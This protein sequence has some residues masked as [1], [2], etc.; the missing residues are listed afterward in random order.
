M[1][2]SNSQQALRLCISIV[3]YQSRR[4]ELEALFSSLESSIIYV[5]Q[6]MGVAVQVVL[7]DNGQQLSLL[8]KVLEGYPALEPEYL[9]VETNIG[10]GCA[11]NL[12]ISSTTADYHLVMNPDLVLKPDTLLK[13]L[14]ELERNKTIVALIPEVC[15]DTGRRQYLCKNYPTVFALALRGFAPAWLR[16]IFDQTLANYECRAMVDRGLNCQVKLASGCFMLCRGAALRQLKGFDPRF[17]LYFEDFALSLELARLG[18]LNYYPSMQIAHFGGHAARKG[19][20]HILYF[21]RSA[22]SFFNL[23]GWRWW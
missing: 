14:R 7:V 16:R 5:K 23:Y 22:T 18:S 9:P 13:G 4:D 6:Q 20:R 8:Q 17:F 21:T 19:W 11:Q 12:A 3:F 15:D 10:Y 2:H 1:P